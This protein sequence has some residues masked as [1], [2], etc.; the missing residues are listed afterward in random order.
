MKKEK[1]GLE[2]KK[3][4]KPDSS[5]IFVRVR[6]RAFRLPLAD[7]P[8]TGQMIAQRCHITLLL[9]LFHSLIFIGF[10]G[11]NEF[12]LRL[13]YATR[14]IINLGYAKKK[15]TLLLPLSLHP[16][17]LYYVS[18]KNE[19]NEFVFTFNDNRICYFAIVELYGCFELIFSAFICS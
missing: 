16:R 15:K 5:R 14:A 11:N 12:R 6:L 8:T 13:T 10:R 7:T 3:S 9:T 4:E 1:R 19:R 17:F 18:P 2:P